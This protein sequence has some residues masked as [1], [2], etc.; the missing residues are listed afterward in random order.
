MLMPF[1]NGNGRIHALGTPQS[2]HTTTAMA[3]LDWYEDPPDPPDRSGWFD[4]DTPDEEKLA[5]LDDHPSL[6]AQD[7]NPSLARR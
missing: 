6:T 3:L 2:P 1:P 4:E 7:R 5:I